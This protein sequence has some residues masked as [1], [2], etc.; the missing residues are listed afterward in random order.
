MFEMLLKLIGKEAPK[1]AD[2]E[3]TGQ[4]LSPAYVEALIDE[5]G[6]SAVFARARDLGWTNGMLPPLWVWNQIAV[7]IIQQKKTS[8][9]MA[10][11][12]SAVLN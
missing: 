5:A 7:E 2:V 11:R 12:R 10:E 8:D 6:R 9:A 4:T 3:L 1:A